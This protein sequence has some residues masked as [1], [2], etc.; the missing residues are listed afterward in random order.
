MGRIALIS[1]VKLV[2]HE[3]ALRISQFSGLPQF[4][5]VSGDPSLGS[6]NG[7]TSYSEILLFICMIEFLRSPCLVSRLNLLP[8]ALALS[9]TQHIMLVFLSKSVS[10]VLSYTRLIAQF[11][12]VVLN[13]PTLI[14]L[15]LS[16]RHCKSAHTLNQIPHFQTP[17]V[18]L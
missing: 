4:V 17:S 8:L 5:T 10:L 9:W 3:M 15:L 11:I 6:F 2:N 7:G 18:L 1:I 16:D 13:P 14:I 12:W